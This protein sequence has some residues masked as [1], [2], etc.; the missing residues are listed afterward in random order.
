MSSDTPKASPYSTTQVTWSAVR[1]VGATG[2]VRWESALVD[3]IEV[4]VA[5]CPPF[6]KAHGGCRDGAPGLT[7]GLPRHG[8][9]V[10]HRG[11]GRRCCPA[12][13]T[14]HT[15]FQRA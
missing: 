1:T 7:R 6:Y 10:D 8:W 2:P 4:I 9:I 13:P 15:V 5:I 3:W 11:E 12:P 14:P